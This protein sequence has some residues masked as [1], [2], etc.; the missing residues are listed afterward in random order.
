MA[1]EVL[2]MARKLINPDTRQATAFYAALAVA[3]YDVVKPHGGFNVW[4]TIVLAS[5]A[6]ITVAGALAAILS[7]GRPAAPPDEKD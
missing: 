4:N 7:P 6:G 5:A 3:I 1:A 2:E